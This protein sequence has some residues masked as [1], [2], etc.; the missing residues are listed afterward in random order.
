M[1]DLYEKYGYY[2]DDVK[3]I[4]LKGIEGLAKI[5]EIMTTLR[6]NTPAQIGE[7]KVLKARDYKKDT[8]TDLETGAVTPTGLP[9]SNVLY[10]ELPDAAWVCFR[11]SGTEPKLKFY[12]DV[13]ADSMEAA[14]AKAAELGA[15]VMA[16]V[17][18][19]LG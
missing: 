11:P 17:E 6:D 3:A 7:H 10:Y 14:D 1:L 19:M 8:I 5:Q 16:I 9:N 15:A 12:Y 13:K 2:K 18:P 4:T